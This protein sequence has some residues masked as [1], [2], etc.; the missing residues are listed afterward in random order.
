MRPVLFRGALRAAGFLA[1]LAVAWVV[2]G[3]PVWGGF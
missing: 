2:G 3:A 1:A